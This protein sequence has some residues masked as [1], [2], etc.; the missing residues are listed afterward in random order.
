M[1][2]VIQVPG[3]LLVIYCPSED[4]YD[5][6]SVEAVSR[7]LPTAAAWLRAR[8]RSNGVGCGQ[9]GTGV[10]FLRVLRFLLSIRIPLIAP[11]SSSSSIIPI[12]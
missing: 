9:S 3:P 6:F 7:R 4:V 1:L 12:I 10:S 8:V 11:Q 5:L 2:P